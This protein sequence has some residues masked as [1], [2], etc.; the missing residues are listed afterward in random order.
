PN[1]LAVVDILP[2]QSANCLELGNGNVNC[3]IDALDPGQAE[4]ILI[5]VDPLQPGETTN[6]VFSTNFMVEDNPA[7]N[8][9]SAF[10][11][12]LAPGDDNV[13]LDKVVP[14]VVD[15]DAGGTIQVFGANFL[16]ITQLLLNGTPISF[17]QEAGHPDAILEVTIPSD[18]E[19]GEYTLL[20]QNTAGNLDTLFKGLIVYDPD[21]LKV[22][23]VVPH[24]GANDRAMMLN[25]AGDGFVPG[26]TGELID[27]NNP[28]LIYPLETPSFVSENLVRALVPYGTPAG[29]YDVR[30]VNPA[31][32]S[33]TLSMAYESLDWTT[34]D[35]LGAFDFDFFTIPA[36][37]REGDDVIVGLTVRR[38]TGEEAPFSSGQ[39][40]VDVNLGVS[41]GELGPDITLGGSGVISPNGT[42]SI[43]FPWNPALAGD[44]HLTLD[45]SSSD[46]LTDTIAS[47]NQIDR[48]VAVLPASTDSEVPVI[49]A[50]TING[51]AWITAVPAVLL[52]TTASDVGSGLDYIYYIEYVFDRNLGDWYPVNRSNWLPFDSAS[53]DFNWV[54]APVAGVHYLQAWVSDQEGNISQPFTSLINLIAAKNHIGHDD[55]Q[56]YR[57]PLLPA[58]FLQ[59]DLTSLT[60]DADLYVWAPDGTLAAAAF[61]GEPFEQ[62]IIDTGVN[63]PGLY[64]FDVYGYENTSYWFET[65]TGGSL[66][67]PLSIDEVQGHVKGGDQTLQ[68]VDNNPGSDVNIPTPP[69][70]ETIYLPL[71]VR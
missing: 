14:N 6:F 17:T 40:S 69:G 56:I 34:A 12:V 21:A 29:V 45:I 16:P 32:I 66:D 65:S 52:N 8:S 1:T 68:V 37:P 28:L 50:L 47:N 62:V 58:S 20:A 24:M 53:E 38:R 22:D 2:S 41:G 15:R 60:G 7:N 25:I 27:S 64:Q 31:G 42:I 59:V 3:T 67:T 23:A 70:D 5:V 36:A 71:I 39:V 57:L 54:L 44:Y 13:Y 49:S 26:M 11:R 4:Q 35:D 33:D 55:G 48:Y 18:F 9:T 19:T 30:L 63:A 43:T 46:L 10:V 61:G 51:G